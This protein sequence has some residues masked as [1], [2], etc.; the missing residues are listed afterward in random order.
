MQAVKCTTFC[1]LAKVSQTEKRFLCEYSDIDVHAV[2]W[3][4]SRL[5]IIQTRFFDARIFTHGTVKK[6]TI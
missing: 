5:E 6:I 4:G 2:R 3:L 1:M